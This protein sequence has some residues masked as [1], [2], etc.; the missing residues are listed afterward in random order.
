MLNEKFKLGIVC[1]M[2]IIFS[3]SIIFSQQ[4][5]GELKNGFNI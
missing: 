5:K 4:E 1:F 2:L 3:S